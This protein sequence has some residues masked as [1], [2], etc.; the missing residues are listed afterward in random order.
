MLPPPL[1]FQ[2]PDSTPN[3]STSASLALTRATLQQ[4]RQQQ[5]LGRKSPL[6]VAPPQA[7]PS[8]IANDLTIVPDDS[9]PD[10]A[11]L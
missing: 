10:F 6:Q 11:D 7:Q 1:T 5:E 4:Q 3:P 9:K 2:P 8:H